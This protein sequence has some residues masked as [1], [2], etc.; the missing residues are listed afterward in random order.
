MPNLDKTGPTG[1][2]PLT[3]HG[4]GACSTKGNSSAGNGVGGGLG[5]G[6]GRMGGNGARNGAGRGLGR[7]RASNA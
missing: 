4:R 2:G 5:R 6:M 1:Q 3:G 7:G